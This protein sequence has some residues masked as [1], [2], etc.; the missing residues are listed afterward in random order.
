MSRF[1]DTMYLLDL[2]IEVFE[3]LFSSYLGLADLRT[4]A[5]VCSASYAV[6]HVIRSCSHASDYAPFHDSFRAS[7]NEYNVGVVKYGIVDS[8]TAYL[9]ADAWKNISFL[10]KVDDAA[11]PGDVHNQWS[12]HPN[13]VGVSYINHTD[14]PSSGSLWGLLADDQHLENLAIL[15]LERYVMHWP[16]VLHLCTY[17]SPTQPSG[18]LKILFNK[19]HLSFAACI[20]L[21][22]RLSVRVTFAGQI[23][24]RCNIVLYSVNFSIDAGIVTLSAL[25]A[26]IQSHRKLVGLE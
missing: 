3:V 11:K 4:F 7:K 21:A 22:P 8:N 12:T 25:A 16:T 14:A 9:V 6:A 20:H 23:L 19:I 26:G 18:Y 15:R 2:P 17:A 13:I 24:S 10:V 5:Q 1:C